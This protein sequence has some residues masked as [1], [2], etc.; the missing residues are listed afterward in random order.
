M[1]WNYIIDRLVLQV[2]NTLQQKMGKIDTNN[3]K[4]AS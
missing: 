3:N 1:S 4:V 2:A